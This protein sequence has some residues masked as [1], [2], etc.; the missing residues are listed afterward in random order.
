MTGPA[1]G[2]GTEISTEIETLLTTGQVSYA[3]FKNTVMTLHEQVTEG[4][5]TDA[6]ASLAHAVC[7]TIFPALPT[8]AFQARSVASVSG[9]SRD[10]CG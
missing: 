9:L 1:T 8:D 7:S 10:E 6:Y 2:V 5:E 3:A 4:I